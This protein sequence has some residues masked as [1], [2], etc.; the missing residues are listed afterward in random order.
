MTFYDIIKQESPVKDV[1]WR[2]YISELC[3]DDFVD[4][5]GTYEVYLSIK[6]WFNEHSPEFRFYISE[7]ESE[8]ERFITIEWD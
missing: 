6:E 7:D 5:Y 4:F 2:I 1:L 8:Y 3:G